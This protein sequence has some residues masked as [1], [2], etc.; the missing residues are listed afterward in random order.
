MLFFLTDE[1]VKELL[2]CSISTVLC[3]RMHACS[4]EYSLSV[5]LITDEGAGTFANAL[6]V[7]KSLQNLK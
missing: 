2:S 6:K 3:E 4:T 1:D 5:N 7:N